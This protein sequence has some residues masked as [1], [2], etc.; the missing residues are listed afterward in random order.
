MKTT[1]FVQEIIFR[2]AIDQRRDVDDDETFFAIGDVNEGIEQID[3]LLLIFRQAHPRGIERER[4][5]QC[6]GRCEFGS[7]I[8]ALPE[9]RNRRGDDALGKSFLI[10]VRDIENF[11]AARSV[12][13][14]EIF[15]AQNDILN[16]TRRRGDTLPEAPR[17]ARDAFGNWPGRQFFA[18]D[19]Q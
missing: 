10:D 9:R 5:R 19:F 7:N 14:V 18:D 17:L 15:A 13:R 1:S 2:V 3:R 6:D 12:R 8:G 16:I 4:A 11:E